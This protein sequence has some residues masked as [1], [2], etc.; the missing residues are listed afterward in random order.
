MLWNLRTSLTHTG[1][2][3]LSWDMNACISSP[4]LEDN[5]EMMIAACMMERMKAVK[6][7]FSWLIISQIE[8]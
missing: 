4:S 5:N 7:S 6:L 1:R 8:H 3:E 2:F